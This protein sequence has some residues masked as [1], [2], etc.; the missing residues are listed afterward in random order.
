MRILFVEWNSYASE[1]VKDAFVRL[2]T[3]L[4]PY[5]LPVGFNGK[6]DEVLCS[7]LAKTIIELRPDFCFSLNYFP[8]IAIACKAAGTRYIS[9]TY[10][11]P[12]SFLYSDTIKFDTNYAFIFDREEYLKLVKLGVE[13]VYHLPLGVPSAT[14]PLNRNLINKYVC[15]ISHIGS[16]YN[17]PKHLLFNKFEGISDYCRGFLN[18][19]IE[20]QKFLYG[21]DITEAGLT[22]QIIEELRAHAPLLLPEDELQSA[23]WTYSKYFLLRETTRREREEYLSAIDTSY[24]FNLYTG[25]DISPSTNA[26]NMGRIDYYKEMP[27]AIKA[28][29][30]NLNISLRSIV[31]GIPLRV[32]DIMG[33][34]A[35]LMTNYQS[36]MFDYF[37]PDEDFVFFE[38]PMDFK[39]KIAFY[40]AH[41]SLREKIAASAYEK[42]ISEH[43]YE[44]RLNC[45]I[46]TV[47]DL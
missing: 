43:T 44:H 37:V 11:S 30:I 5:K 24:R 32:W 42:V 26:V 8:I 38:N 34:N 21:V 6:N 36:E 40:M 45:M 7:D 12:Y 4:I 35:F 14:R 31:S 13:T 18:G 23:A 46:N 2:G 3:T 29:K 39:D 9:W 17:E 41:D 33:T 25:G 15:D 19:L 10:D 22:D 27:E 28:S 20:S 1:Y 16:L 47:F